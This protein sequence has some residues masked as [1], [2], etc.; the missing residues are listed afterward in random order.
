LVIL[1]LTG[2]LL[3]ITWRAFEVSKVWLWWNVVV[4]AFPISAFLL[5]RTFGPS[6]LYLL[7]AVFFIAELFALRLS[8]S[9]VEAKK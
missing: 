5:E 1:G 2:H 7:I 3:Y 8:P 6:Q 4:T 9:I